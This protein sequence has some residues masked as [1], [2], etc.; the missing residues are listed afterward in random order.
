MG[1]SWSRDKPLLTIAVLRL[2]SAVMYLL[3]AISFPVE[4]S[5]IRGAVV[6][7]QPV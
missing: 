1:N 2:V 6:E 3:L 7:E 5:K 4:H